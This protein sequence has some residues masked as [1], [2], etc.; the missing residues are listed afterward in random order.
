MGA[1]SYLLGIEVTRNRAEHRLYLSQR[2]YVINK[3]EEFGMSECKPVT[4]PMTPSLA[5]SKAQSP[6][7]EEEAN[8]MADIPYISAVGSLLYLATMTWPDI[9]YAAR[10]T[11]TIQL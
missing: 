3:L 7:T 8:E 6:Q 10:S 2:Q 11:C 9:A 1:T 4:T 5:L